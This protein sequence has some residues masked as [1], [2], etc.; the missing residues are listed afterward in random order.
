[1][2]ERKLSSLGWAAKV[3][4][5]FYSFAFF[6]KKVEI[7][8]KFF[9]KLHHSGS[10]LDEP[11]KTIKAGAH[12]VP[13]G[14]NMLV[15]DDGSL[16]YYTVRESARIQTFPDDYLFHGSWTESMRQIG[17]AVPVKLAYIIGQSVA[18]LINKSDI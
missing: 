6:A 17:N 12:G 16:R 2:N 7:F 10:V 4:L 14:E 8:R 11:S 1:N 18:E 9:G 3:F 5:H 13:G 15:L